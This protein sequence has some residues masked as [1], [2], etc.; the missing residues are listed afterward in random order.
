MDAPEGISFAASFGRMNTAIE[1]TRFVY[2]SLASKCKKSGETSQVAV[3]ITAG[4]MPQP[5]AKR[6]F[7]LERSA[8]LANHANPGQCLL[9]PAAR[10]LARP[11]LAAGYMIIVLGD[12]RLGNS[13][14]ADKI[15]QLCIPGFPDD[16]PR[17]DALD[18]IASNI[19][20][21]ES[22]IGRDDE[23]KAVRQLIRR[24]ELVTIYG[25]A[26][27]GK[28]SLAQWIAY[29]LAEDYRDGA[30]KVD[31]A[32]IP[33]NGNV[34][35]AIAAD[36]KLP[37]LQN[38]SAEDR[39][40]VNLSSFKGLVWLD[41]CEHVLHQT[42][43]LLAKII[44][45]CPDVTFLLTSQKK[46]LLPEEAAY[47]LKPFEVPTD[48][49]DIEHS[50]G[51]RLF[52]TRARAANPDFKPTQADYAVIAEICRK[53]DGL[54]L[55]IELAAGQSAK[56]SLTELQ[57]RL[58]E[59]VWA[60]SSGPG[61]KQQTL[62]TALSWSYS[63]LD[64]KEKRFFRSLGALFGWTN[65]ELTIAIGTT[66]RMSEEEGGRLLDSLVASSLIQERKPHKGASS[67]RMLQPVREFALDLLERNEELEPARNKVAKE[68]LAWLVG[69]KA[70]LMRLS[71][72]V[73]AVHREKSNVEGSLE[74]LLNQP[75]GGRD[76]LTACTELYDYWIRKG[77]YDGA[78][79][80]YERA[81]ATGK[82]THAADLPDIYIWMGTFAGYAGNYDAS[83]AA[84]EKAIK[85]HEKAGNLERVAV[86]MQNLAI[87]LRN[88]DR[89]DEAIEVARKSVE[90]CV[91]ENP[92][93]AMTVGNLA[94]YLAEGGFIEE[95]KEWLAKAIA[96]NEKEQDPWAKACHESQLTYL[97]LLENNSAEAEFHASEALAAYRETDN[98]QGLLATIEA[99][100]FIALRLG[101]VE[102]AA[103]LI[104]G[105]DKQF[106]EAGV[107]RPPRD[108]AKKN[109]AR[110]EINHALG[111][112]A[113]ACY[114][115]GALMSIDELYD[116]ARRGNAFQF[117]SGS[118]A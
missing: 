96:L 69:L 72:W 98:L 66:P 86:A 118:T 60:T 76:A 59:G 13:L 103:K 11:N 90:L 7:A 81:I 105:S 94:F 53:L 30:Y 17:I 9:G 113:E 91:P 65:R 51:V 49:T 18:D 34:A 110:E 79:R 93:G 102:R 77:P 95:A 29:D 100:G 28:S 47:E 21:L 33:A 1:F 27:V 19:K 8:E 40:L 48:A 85:L 2:E 35:T 64:D 39:V 5:P 44:D 101:N 83:I 55:A 23:S 112:A 58:T 71:Q 10:E 88:A 67:F 73:S 15:G 32:N 43:K 97:A 38:S 14:S 108:E 41:N 20:E 62:R 115:L 26:G 31:F 52:E 22:F 54:P 25:P 68:F 16:F 4:D 111:D 37:S 99:A 56:Q 42:K 75:S 3:A 107:G 89:L 50:D 61:P 82:K 6:I 70:K 24:N 117:P 78:H 114:L 63:L 36:L 92:G 46:L 12:M 106:L 109:E 87:H 74:V 116:F 104:G 45:L 57:Q 84:F 80:W